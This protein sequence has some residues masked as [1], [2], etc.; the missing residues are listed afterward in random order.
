M[1][2]INK[3]RLNNFISGI[4]GVTPG[5]TAVINQPVNLRAHRQ[6]Y[7]T[8][9][10]AYGL[11]ATPPVAVP[12]T[13]DAGATFTLTTANGLV[14]GIAIVG[15]VSTK[16][17]G[18]YPLTITDGLYTQLD[19]T[20]VAIGKGATGTYT[21]ATGVVTA[22]AITSGGV[23]A[24]VPPELLLTS[25]KES[26]NG[27]NMRDITPANRI[28]IALANPR[29]GW[30][31]VT[32]ELPIF[33][34]EPWRNLNGHNEIT[35]WDLAG[36]NTWQLQIGIAPNI[37]A[38]SLVGSY[39]FDFIRNMRPS[40]AGGKRVDVPFLQ[41]V[42]QHQFSF[43]VPAGRFDLN[44]LPFDFPISRVWLYETDLNTNVPLGVGSIV[45][46]EIYQ[47]NNKIL[48]TTLAQN[49]QVLRE[50]GFATNIFD[51]AF[52]ADIDQRLYKALHCEKQFII[53]VYS[54]NAANLNVVLE[55]LP[56]AF[57]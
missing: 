41:P 15:A 27:V 6:N 57:Q 31:L 7:Q 29:N 20:P 51:A 2:V 36:Q 21:V 38:P 11:G 4:T 53:R 5:G 3:G 28:K 49:Q 1:S 40:V 42:K 24:P 45:Q 33:Y 17:D 13:A 23:V 12:A 39:E 56:G 52:V 37:S 47:D 48:E 55:T 43:P 16:A 50:Y 14:S 35:S 19:G 30:T 44:T 22:A 10:I 8:A 32:G 18:T 34:T 54:A 46:V 26:V 9:G 25:I